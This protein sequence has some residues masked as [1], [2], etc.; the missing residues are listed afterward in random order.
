LVV[1]ISKSRINSGSQP[2]RIEEFLKSEIC[3]DFQLKNRL[4]VLDSNLSM[5]TLKV[6][7]VN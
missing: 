3:S 6:S 7:R 2:K 4:P 1:P 5:E